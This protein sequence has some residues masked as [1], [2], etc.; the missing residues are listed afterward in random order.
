MASK[1]PE[2]YKVIHALSENNAS[3]EF[4]VIKKHPQV[5]VFLLI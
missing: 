5:R 4:K 2:G 3:A 1:F